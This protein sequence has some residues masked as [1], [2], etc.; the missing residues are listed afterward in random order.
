APVSAP[1]DIAWR[2]ADG[3]TTAGGVG[4]SGKNDNRLFKVGFQPPKENTNPPAADTG[5]KDL[6]FPPAPHALAADAKGHIHFAG[7]PGSPVP[8]APNELNPILL[9]AYVI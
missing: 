9:P 2:S 4:K 1:S 8:I 7:L 6:D 5:K 3:A